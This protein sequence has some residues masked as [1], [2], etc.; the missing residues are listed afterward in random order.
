MKCETLTDKT[1]V[2]PT[3]TRGKRTVVALA[4][5]PKAEKT[6]RGWGNP[7][8]QALIADGM[9]GLMSGRMYDANLCFVGMVH[10]IAKLATAEI[11]DRTKKATDKKLHN[12]FMLT[13]KNLGETME[14]LKIRDKSEPHF[15]VLD[16]DG[17]I[18]YHTSGD[19]TDDKLNQITEKLM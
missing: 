2:I 18:I 1:V 4:M 9:G 14:A 12:N 7:L 16:K 17:N 3:D 10:G 19:Y 15:F 8:Y 5:S 6:L 13:E 11:K